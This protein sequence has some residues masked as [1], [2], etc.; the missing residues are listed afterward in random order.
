MK[1][2][3]FKFKTLIFKKKGFTLI[4]TLVYASVF[5]LVFLIVAGFV[6]WFSYYNKKAK[7]DREVLEN[8]RSAMETILYEI[9]KAE[10]VYT[11]TSSLN[12]LSLQTFDYLPAGEAS[13]YIDFFLCGARVCFKKESQPP[14]F[15]TPETI[16]V[17]S[18]EFTQI[19]TN[20]AASVRISFTAD[21]KTSSDP[22]SSVNLVSTASLRSY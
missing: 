3:N 1:I 19:S 13:S 12:Q 16:E 2:A 6:F 9:K 11:P 14:V 17:S 18:L 10:S 15:L 21:Y 20:G 22:G 8:S 7:A 4:E 5:A